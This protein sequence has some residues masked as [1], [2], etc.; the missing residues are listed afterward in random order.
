MDIAFIDN[1]AYNRDSFFHKASVSS[2]LLFVT[3]MI[4][5]VVISR[6]PLILL[7]SLMVVISIIF[8]SGLPVR[9]L[10]PFAGYALFFSAIF[11]FASFQGSLIVPITIILKALLAS[12]SLILLVSTTPYIEIFSAFKLF[13]PSSLVDIMFVTYRS[14]FILLEFTSR[15]FTAV[16][17]R[18][19]YSKLSLIKNLRSI[20]RMMAHTFVH[21]WEMSERMENIMT[22]RGYESGLLGKSRIGN[23]SKYDIFPIVSG[24]LIL[25][26]AV[27]K[28]I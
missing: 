25:L 19:G 7:F 24:L 10:L 18:G 14:F 1:L 28:A 22:I 16:K 3:F 15:F 12:I 8:F 23:P 26:V 27:V 17:I 4:S 11:A 6:N 2:K 9:K 5:T 21:A 13:M 20:S